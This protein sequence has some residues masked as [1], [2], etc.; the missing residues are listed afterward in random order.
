MG[1]GLLRSIEMRRCK[2][3]AVDF[4]TNFFEKASKSYK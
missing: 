2:P 1:F 3:R 4:M